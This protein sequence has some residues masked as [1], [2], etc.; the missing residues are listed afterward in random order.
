METAVI[1]SLVIAILSAII[2]L[3]TAAIPA[4]LNHVFAEWTA[5]AKSNADFNTHKEP[6][7]IAAI[8][9]AHE[10]FNFLE[11]GNKEWIYWTSAEEKRKRYNSTAYLCYLF[12]IFFARVDALQKGVQLLNLGK[13]NVKLYKV[14]YDIQLIL[15]QKP[16]VGDQ[17]CKV[18]KKG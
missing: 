7:L 1:V 3:F 6:V 13:S 15:F 10:L 9:L 17:P 8:D 11:A 18:V 14:L 16:D 2:S 4:W 5:T 12:A